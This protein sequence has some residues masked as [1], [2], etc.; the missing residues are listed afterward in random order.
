[1]LVQMALFH[2]F[3]WLRTIPLYICTTSCLPI[4]SV[5]GHLGRFYVLAVL[6]G[7]VMNIGVHVSFLCPGMLPNGR[8]AGIN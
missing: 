1:M 5:N 6:S 8:E 2:S 7:A 4:S 3:L